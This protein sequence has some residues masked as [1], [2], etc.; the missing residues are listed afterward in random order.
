MWDV[1]TNLCPNCIGGLPESPF[2]LR[3]EWVIE[4]I[5]LR[6]WNYLYTS[7]RYLDANLANFCL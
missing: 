3:Y 7:R 4:P 2:K 6:G 1:I 5:V